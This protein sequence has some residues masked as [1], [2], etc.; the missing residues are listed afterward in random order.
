M[1]AQM[2]MMSMSA[3]LFFQAQH[4]RLNCPKRRA[5]LPRL[6]PLLDPYIR[7][8]LI[9]FEITFKILKILTEYVELKNSLDTK[10]QKRFTFCRR[11]F[12]ISVTKKPNPA[13]YSIAFFSASAFFFDSTFSFSLLAFARSFL[14]FSLGLFIFKISRFLNQTC[15]EHVN[16]K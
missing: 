5:L 2:K 12:N 3:R 6:F 10:L 8:F 11:I 7:G 16:L 9:F 14:F 1:M 4:L 13:L 15:A